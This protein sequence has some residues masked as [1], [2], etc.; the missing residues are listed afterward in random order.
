MENILNGLKDSFQDYQEKVINLFQEA[1]APWD[2]LFDSNTNP[3]ICRGLFH[4]IKKFLEGDK[5]QLF[6]QLPTDELGQNDENQKKNRLEI[7]E[8]ITDCLF[9]ATKNSWIEHYNCPNIEEAKIGDF[10]YF[11][12]YIW[13]VVASSNDGIPRPKCLDPKGKY[14]PTTSESRKLYR[15]SQESGIRLI[16]NPDK[17]SEAKKVA[18]K[19]NFYRTLPATYNAEQCILIGA[20]HFQQNP[21]VSCGNIHTPVRFAT[22]YAQFV[23]EPCDI[24]VLLWDRKY[25]NFEIQINNLIASGDVKKVIY[26]GTEI[27]DGFK[28]N[29]E[30]MSFSFTYREIFSYYYNPS[31]E[32]RNRFPNIEFKKVSFPYLYQEVETLNSYIPGEFSKKDRQRILGLAL[33]PFL[34]RNFEDP[35]TEGLR[36]ILYNDYDALSNEAIDNIVCWVDNFACIGKTPKALADPTSAWTQTFYIDPKSSYKRD[37]SKHLNETNNNK[38]TYIIDAPLNVYKVVD[39]VKALLSRGALGKYIILSYFELPK[40][41]EF[42]ESEIKVYKNSDRFDLLGIKFDSEIKQI[43]AKSSNLL[44]YYNDDFTDD[45]L[46][47]GNEHKQ[48]IQNLKFECKFENTH[49]DVILENGLVIYFS[50]TIKVEDIYNNKA[51]YLP[52]KITYYQKPDN[53]QELMKLYYPIP[54]DQSVESFVKFWK[55]KLRDMLKIRYNG[56]LN[57]MHKDFKFLS[58]K[59]LGKITKSSY[60][61]MFTHKIDSIAN[62]MARHKFISA[63]DAICIKAAHDIVG[64]Y[65]INGQRLKASLIEYQLNG[66]IDKFLQELLYNASRKGVKISADSLLSQCMMT[67]TLIDITKKK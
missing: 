41:K 14:K 43:E 5:T 3:D 31:R 65:S 59:E 57:L 18:E 60:R 61:P 53:F 50:N 29:S 40:L 13:E 32:Y 4:I 55:E 46:S 10:C 1:T 26:L 7:Q 30:N 37:L 38:Q 52:C 48:N 9:L 63:D 25:R 27:F 45:I 20:K 11:D 22:N 24:L 28:E 6:I 17:L 67:Q 58:L 66:K 23:N 64:E 21:L 39:C 34:G 19:I 49:E 47:Y 12:D 8:T 16:S 2:R 44:D 42:F 51:D 35:N 36:E 33:R 62:V 54:A 56:D 15:A